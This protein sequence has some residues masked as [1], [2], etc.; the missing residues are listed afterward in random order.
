VGQ[1]APLSCIEALQHALSTG[2]QGGKVVH[3][4]CLEFLV[5]LLD[6]GKNFSAQGNVRL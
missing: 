5:F 2:L 4:G 6:N 1:D 3:R